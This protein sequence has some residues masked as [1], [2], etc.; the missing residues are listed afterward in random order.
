MTSEDKSK[1]QT[2]AKSHMSRAKSVKEW[3]SL[4]EQL[5]TVLAKDEIVKDFV[6]RYIDT[7]PGH[8]HMVGNAKSLIYTTLHQKQCS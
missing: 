7:A 2:F 8:S 5:S 1:V 3:N 6:L 4:R